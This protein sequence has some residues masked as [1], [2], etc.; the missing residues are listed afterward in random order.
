MRERLAHKLPLS[1][2]YSITVTTS[3]VC[4]LKCEYCA[5]SENRKNRNKSFIDWQTFQLVVDRLIESNWHLKQIIFVGLGEP[6]L[7]KDIVKF[8]RYAKAA[9]I[10]DKV[11]IVSN[12]TLL[13][14][15][16][17]DALIDAGL[18]VMRFS[19][20]GL[21]ADDYL[22]YTGR[23][24][25]F[26]AMIQR[27]QYFYDA[28]PAS[29]KIYSKIMDYMVETEEKKIKFEEIFG[30]ISD[31]INIEYMTQM[32]T[33]LDY[34]TIAPLNAKKGLKG[35]RTKD[36]EVCP[37]P[38]YHIYV[39][40]E[41]TVS[42][43]CVAGPWYVPPALEMGDLHEKTFDEIYRSPEGDFHKFLLRMLFDGREK[44]S[45][46]CRRCKA[47]TSYIYPEDVIDD[48]RYRIAEDM[49]CEQYK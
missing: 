10:A 4:N 37:L 18:D 12:G 40:A 32:S 31:V 8:V 15:V 17:G 23:T 30:R 11:H 29:L 9:N 6:L 16:L 46:I 39:N 26:P 33:T 36:V 20:N 35:F 34:S 48:E 5:I 19:I 41:G 3:N 43:C 1:V 49:K 38:F 25:D 47:Y 7:N 21:S 13:T 2:P 44:A 22:K 45:E 14:E 42:A 28:K 27:M 24:I